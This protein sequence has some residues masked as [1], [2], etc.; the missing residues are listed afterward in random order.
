MPPVSQTISIQK[1]VA[2]SVTIVM[3]PAESVDGW[4]MSFRAKGSPTNPNTQVATILA[5]AVSDAV[6]QIVV[7][8]TRGFPLDGPFKVRVDNEVMQV[9]DGV[10]WY[11]Q[12]QL[13]LIWTVERGAWG[14][15][16]AAHSRR[17]RVTLFNL[18]QMLLDTGTHGGVSVEDADTGVILVTFDATFTAERPVGT[19]FWS[20]L[21]T[22]A[23]YERTLAE[24]TLYLLPGNTSA[25]EEPPFGG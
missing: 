21:R 16:P 13:N 24:G 6:T 4:N 1:G 5:D 25:F 23:G 17:A 20:L 18:P 2:E 14:T 8:T 12:G 11:S 19:Y 7:N 22:D 3:K 15:T 9:T 10:Q